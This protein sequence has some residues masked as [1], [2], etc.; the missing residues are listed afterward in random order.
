MKKQPTERKSGAPV[1]CSDLVR[2]HFPIS[3]ILRLV[4]EWRENEL[5]Q[6]I[7]NHRKNRVL[8]SL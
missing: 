3:E 6:Q 4:D 5:K 2:C 7:I 8:N 1:R